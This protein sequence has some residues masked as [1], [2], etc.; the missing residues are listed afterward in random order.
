MQLNIN[1]IKNQYVIFLKGSVF[2]ASQ[3]SKKR[4]TDSDFSMTHKHRAGNTFFPYL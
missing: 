1:S 4:K 3:I 2:L